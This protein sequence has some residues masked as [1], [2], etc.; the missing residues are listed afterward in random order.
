MTQAPVIVGAGPAGCAAAI[1]LCRQGIGPTLIDRNAKAN[2]AIC[3]GFISW[4]TAE[5]LHTL[6]ID[7]GSLGGH[8]VNHLR[9]FTQRQAAEVPLPDRAYGLSRG[10][11]DQAMRNRAHELGARLTVDTV[12]GFEPDGVRGEHGHYEAETVFHATGKHDVRGMSRPRDTNETA[13]GLRVRIGPERNLAAT[14]GDAIELHLFDGG[15][16][17]I[18]LQEDSTANICLAVRKT[19]LRDS[20]NDPHRLLQSLGDRYRQFGVRIGGLTDTQPV[21]TIGSV[22]YGWIAQNTRAGFYRL[23]DQAAVIPSLAGE[24]MSIAVHSGIHAADIWLERGRDGAGHYQRSFAEWAARP[25]SVAR[26][27]WRIGETRLLSEVLAYAAGRMPWLAGS[28]MKA[29]RLAA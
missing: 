8:T 9:I 24:G 28:V 5:T 2:D 3:G 17:G 26:L 14:I 25:V 29:T 6:D 19:L 4:R 23:G 10:T 12:R 1:S 27:A 13:I 15:Y 18:V 7:P 16:A 20:G 21:D 11:L 22:P